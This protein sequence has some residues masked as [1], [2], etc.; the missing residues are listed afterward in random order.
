MDKQ[1]FDP[2]N[3]PL[4]TGIN[5]LE[6]SAGTGKTYAIAMLILRFV[7]ELEIDIKEL[8]VVTFTKAATE[9]LINR[10]RARLAE[11]RRA[12]DGA[13]ATSDATL[14]RW[15]NAVPSEQRK[16]VKERLDQAL[17]DIDQASVFTIHGFCQRILSEHALE[18]G[19]LFDCE[20]TGDIA[21]IKQACAD[22]FWR[23]TLYQ[24]SA[25]EVSVLTAE[26]HSPD[27]LLQS[28]EFIPERQAI[29]PDYI[30]LD[31]LFT[32]LKRH[33][34]SVAKA[35]PDTVEKI[36]TVMSDGKFKASYALPEDELIL[37]DWLNGHGLTFPDIACLTSAGLRDGLN[38]NKFRK[39][40]NNPL[41]SDEQ[42]IEYLENLCFDYA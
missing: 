24:R 7:V 3:T 19:Q 6:A 42:K 4:R 39:S 25:W 38:G 29:F 1:L 32:E 36:R 2:V 27:T 26:Y 9:E 40:K 37:I 35:L 8:L 12:I 34:Q 16:A 5:L 17:L 33:N 10:I 28:V 22:D 21:T 20:L 11:A 15:I 31:S 23:S 41:S 30:E 18:S 13:Y 14:V